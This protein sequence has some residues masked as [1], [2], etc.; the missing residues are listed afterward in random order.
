L[1]VVDRG[2]NRKIS[3]NDIGGA[4]G[5]RIALSV[6]DRGSNKRV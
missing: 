5:S 3:K 2:S 4:K 1:S 6:V